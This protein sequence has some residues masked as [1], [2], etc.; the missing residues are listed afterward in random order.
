MTLRIEPATGAALERAL[1][2]LAKLRIDLSM[3]STDAGHA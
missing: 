2:A 3:L 1:P